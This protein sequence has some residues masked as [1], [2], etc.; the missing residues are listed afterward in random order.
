MEKLRHVAI[1]VDGNG[2][3]A[4][5]RGKIRS[6]GHLAG[7]K[8]LERIILHASRKTDI[9]VLSLYV[10]STENFKRSKDEVDYLMNLFMKWFS[11][12][13]K[14]YKKDDIKIIFS[15]RKEPLSDEV[16]SSMKKLEERTK[17]HK[18]LIVNFC[19]NYGGRAEIVDASKK[20]ANEL[21][22]GL[23]EEKDITEEYFSTKLYNKLPDVDYVIR[24]SGEQRIS[25]F[26][27]WEISYAEFLFTPEYFPDFDEK[28]FD[29]AIE[30]YY[31]RDRRFGNVKK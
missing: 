28:C 26:L 22:E 2:R 30:E 27:L 19:L 8:M 10:F 9:E 21:K 23:I 6:E 5:K 15:G 14:K 18:G 13:S 12:S 16:Y 25:N 17:D 1:I 4:K 31:N 29:R 7:S 3:W 24:T 11:V 20:I